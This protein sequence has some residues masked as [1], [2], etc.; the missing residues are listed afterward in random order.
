M[1][2]KKVRE[3]H[4]KNLSPSNVSPATKSAKEKGA[5]AVKAAASKSQAQIV[6]SAGKFKVSLTTALDSIV[7]EVTEQLGTLRE[8]QDAISHERQNLQ[9]LY[10]IQAQAGSLFALIEANEQEREAAEAERLRSAKAWE[11]TTKA[12]ED[13]TKRDREEQTYQWQLKVRKD[14]DNWKEHTRKREKE[15]QDQLASLG[16]KLN[17]D[18]QAFNKKEQRLAELEA[19]EKNS[20]EIHAGQL[21]EATRQANIETTRE[22]TH[23]FALERMALK[24][25]TDLQ[26]KELQSLHKK[27]EELN[28]SNQ[29]LQATAIDATN[30]V[31]AIAEKAVESA[32]RSP[33]N[34]TNTSPTGK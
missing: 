11:D 34:I 9:E 1:A 30:K 33:V 23:A 3:A 21:K 24:N 27:I 13:L 29:K 28:L 20:S 26:Q 5:A 12:R 19:W 18:I 14:E 10:D 31:Q 8:V 15:L 2:A 22:L 4:D 25:M 17:E 7:S 16:Q 32:S 6:E